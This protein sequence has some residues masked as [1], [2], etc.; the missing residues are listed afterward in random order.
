M[1]PMHKP[2]YH[3]YTFIYTRSHTHPSHT[4]MHAHTQTHISSVLTDKDTHIYISTIHVQT[5]NLTLHFS[6]KSTA[7]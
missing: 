7:S 1:P 5:H 3:M 2:I 4:H 6:I